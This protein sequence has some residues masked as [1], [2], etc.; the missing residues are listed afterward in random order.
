MKTV[1]MTLEEE[2][3][4]A[5]DR[6]VKQLGTTRSAFA[7][8]ALR[9]ALK[10]IRLSELQRRHRGGYARK[11]VR[12]RE[13]SVWEREATTAAMG[14]NFHPYGLERYRTQIDMF[15]GEA[16][17]LGLT[18]RHVTTE[19]YFAFADGQIAEVAGFAAQVRGGPASPTLARRAFTR[20][21]AVRKRIERPSVAETEKWLAR[22]G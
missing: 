12:R 18:S 13:F 11:P 19:E 2:L 20:T 17:R 16:F 22:G 3:V 6:A 5:V 10:R 1:Q 14:E 21:L 8:E 4:T 7:R 15:A 9:A